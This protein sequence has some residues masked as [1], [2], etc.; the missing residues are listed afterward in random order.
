[1]KRIS[2]AY[3]TIMC[4]LWTVFVV[5]VVQNVQPIKAITETILIKADGSIDPPSAPIETLDN[6]TY[7]LKNN[8]NGSIVVYRDNIIIDGADC[9]LQGPGIGWTSRGLDLTERSNITV[10]NLIISN[11]FYGIYMNGSLNNILGNKIIWNHLGIMLADS[12]S[13]NIVRNNVEFIFPQGMIGLTGGNGIE[14]FSCR[15][16]SIV[17][18]NITVQG[19]FELGGGGEALRLQDSSD[20]I[21][22]RNYINDSD[23]GVI[24]VSSLNNKIY[25]N[26]FI[27]N[28]HRTVVVNSINIWDDGYPSGGNYWSDYADGDYYQGPSQNIA[29]SD[30]IGDAEYSIDGNNTDH[31][32]LV[33]FFFD[34]NATSEYCVQTICNSTISGFHFWGGVALDF[35]VNGEYG[36]IGFCRVCIPHA[37]IEPGYIVRVDGQPPLSCRTVFSN[38]THT[39]LYFTYHH[40]THE[41][42]I[43]IPEFPSFIILSLFMTLTLIAITFSKRKHIVKA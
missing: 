34:F 10:K 30:G 3:F 41:V 1:M 11:F 29:G 42:Y 5:A 2:L 40:S 14:L 15:N 26:N 19:G 9:S 24:V 27:D 25:H 22:A 23:V 13:N 31:H 28:I 37:L 18:N 4:L 36:T 39:W 7:I 32:P 17:E 38:G 12:T 20:N 33:G 8:I 21:V 43:T 16:N 6:V 35:Y